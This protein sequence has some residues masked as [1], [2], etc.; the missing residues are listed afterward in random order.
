MIDVQ[1]EIKG[2][3][4]IFFIKEDKTRVAELMYQLPGS[5]RMII[6]H[7]EVS[8]KLAGKGLGKRLLDKAVA[9]AREQHLKIIPFCSFAKSVFTKEHAQYEDVL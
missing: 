1:N 6:E 5:N 7:T 8:E 2:D 9:Y 4:G 3:R